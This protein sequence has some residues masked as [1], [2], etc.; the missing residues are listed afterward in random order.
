MLAAPGLS[1]YDFKFD[2]WGASPSTTPGTSVVPGA[3]N[4]EGSWT[5]IASAANIA[6]AIYWISLYVQGGA[7]SAAAKNHLLDIGVDPAGG[8]SYT[9][10]ISD[11][12]VGASQT[13]GGATPH[14]L[15]P[16]FIPAGSSVAVRIQ[17]N[18]NTAGTVRVS[19][20]FYGDPS[21]PE[22]VPVGQ[23][24]ESIGTGGVNSGGVTVTPG[25]GAF[26]SYAQLG[27]T[28]SD[29]WWW[30]FGVQALQGTMTSIPTYF[31]L[32]YGDVTNKVP[33]MKK[34]L[35]P[36]TAEALLH[37][38]DCNPFWPEAY[39]PVPAGSNIY[40]RAHGISAPFS[41]WSATAIGIG[42]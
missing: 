32:S 14:F 21:N 19:A 17:G 27:T 31:E 11:L 3:T 22:L 29:L 8:T 6:K 15:F 41:G 37:D 42:G 34:M 25:N 40:C 24:S 36:N 28:T 39:R 12:P 4:A 20:K 33:F 2:N 18:N 35:E 1:S 38:L 30:Q 9:A 5:Q 23:F 26:G 7:T 10:I 13:A 16:F